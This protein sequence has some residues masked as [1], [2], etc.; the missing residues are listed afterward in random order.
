MISIIIPV[1]NVEKML[2]KCVD[3]MLGQTYTDWELILVDDGSKDSSGRVCDAYAEKDDR[4]R[5]FHKE[6]GGVSSARNL[7]LAE[8]KGNYVGFIDSDD[9]VDST[10]LADFGI[11]KVE[12]D[13][14]ISGALYN[15]YGTDY[16]YKKYKKAFCKDIQEIKE[17]FFEQGLEANGYPWGKLF[18]LSIIKENHLSFNESMTINEDH[19]FVFQFYL[20]ISTLFVTDRAG[21][22]YRVFDNSGRKLSDK[23]NSYKELIIASKAF[24]RIIEKMCLTWNLPQ[25]SVHSLKNSFVYAKRLL[26]LR[27]LLLKNYWPYGTFKDE[28]YFWKTSAEYSGISKKDKAIIGLL[29]AKLPAII[30]LLLLKS[31]FSALHLKAIYRAVPDIYRD[32]ERRSVKIN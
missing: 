9:W 32:L 11:D 28:L 6:N 25:K 24:Q 22:H 15:T 7:G 5:V 13:F 26:A 18:K 10:Y 8:A 4:I 31:I 19:L 14:Y 30:K 29:R 20:C 2:P 23:V 27:S 21:Y 3:S 16:S 12:A 17:T 1:Y